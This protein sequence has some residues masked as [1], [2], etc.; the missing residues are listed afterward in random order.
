[1]VHKCLFETVPMHHVLP[2]IL[3][4]NVDD[5]S[6]RTARYGEEVEMKSSKRFLAIVR[7]DKRLLV[8]FGGI[9]VDVAFLA[10]ILLTAFAWY[11]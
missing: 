2:T 10:A 11:L 3:C 4:D 5:G 1:M 7:G 9:V 6:R 8:M